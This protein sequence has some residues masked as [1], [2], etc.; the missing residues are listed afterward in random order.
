MQEQRTFLGGQNTH[1]EFIVKTTIEQDNGEYTCFVARRHGQFKQLHDRLRSSYPGIKVPMAPSK[2][3][4]SKNLGDLYRE[5]DRILL[6]AYLRRIS[7]HPKLCKS[8]VF[9]D[10]LTKDPVTLTKDE[11]EDAERRSELDKERIEQEIQFKKQVNEK[12]VALN[13]L[14]EMLKNRVMQPGGLVNMMA[15]IKSTETLADLP[16]SLRKAFEWGR[17]RQVLLWITKILVII[18][19]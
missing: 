7:K 19:V 9:H 6:R 11:E 1:I 3:T 12:V 14:M 10:F 18:Q 2:N 8:E 4:R 17:T 16:E 5:Q 15:D 13:D